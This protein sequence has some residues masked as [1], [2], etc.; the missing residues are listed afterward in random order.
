MENS[1]NFKYSNPVIGVTFHRLRDNSKN[2]RVIFVGTVR[3]LGQ[4]ELAFGFCGSIGVVIS[5]L[6]SLTAGNACCSSTLVVVVVV[7][8]ELRF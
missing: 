5:K 3:T 7:V 6:R 4:H 8:K 2:T 1:R